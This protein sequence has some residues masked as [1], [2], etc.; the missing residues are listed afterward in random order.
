MA[1]FSVGEKIFN[2]IVEYPL[3]I[4][5]GT[6]D[7]VFY[8]VAA[9]DPFGA[10]GRKFFNAYF[11]NHKKQDAK[12]LEDIIGI[13][14]NEVTQGGVT[15]IRETIIQA[16]G[17]LQR[18]IFPI[19]TGA[20]FGTSE[21]YFV[22]DDMQ[23]R[24]LQN[25]F[26]DGKFAD[27]NNKRKEVIKHL[28]DDSWITIRACNFGQ[29]ADGLYALY[30]FFGGQANVYCPSV[31]QQFN[32]IG[33]GKG[34]RFETKLMAHEHLVKQRILKRDQT[35]ERKA[36]TVNALVDPAKFSIP[37]QLAQK[38]KGDTSSTSAQQYQAFKDN[39]NNR[40]LTD[41]LKTKLSDAQ[42]QLTDKAK[43]LVIKRDS[44]W[45]ILDNI[46]LENIVFNIEYD[47]NEQT[48]DDTIHEQT[49]SVMAEATLR[50]KTLEDGTASPIGDAVYFQLFI[51]EREHKDF[52]GLLFFLGYN[53]S[54]T[55]LTLFTSLI[56]SLDAGGAVSATIKDIFK[57]ATFDL[58]D[59]ATIT[60]QKKGKTW[61]ITDGDHSVFLRLQKAPA[62]N[63]QAIVTVIAVY[64]NLNAVKFDAMQEDLL[65]TPTF[66]KSPNL[67]GTELLAYLD[68]FSLA[69]LQN[70]IDYLRSPYNPE[71]V[72]YIY[73]AISA[74]DRKNQKDFIAWNAT[75][76]D[77]NEQ[78][79]NNPLLASPYN[80]L[81]IREREDYLELVYEFAVND[82][83]K[84][85]KALNAA[86]KV[87]P[88]DLFT[89][90][91][92]PDHNTYEYEDEDE[93]DSPT[94]EIRG[95]DTTHG[96]EVFQQREKV[97]FQVPDIPELDC[98]AY[99]ELLSKIKTLNT[100]NEEKIL[101]AL[102]D[103]ELSEGLKFRDYVMRGSTILNFTMEMAEHFEA[104][105]HSSVRVLN[106]FGHIVESTVFEVLG[107]GLA[108]LEP[109]VLTLEVFDAEQEGVE[110]HE[111]LGRRIATRQ[112]AKQ[113]QIGI[114]G[115]T[116]DFSKKI[117]LDVH[118]SGSADPANYW[119]DRY[120]AEL[121][122]E[123]K[124]PGSPVN[125]F[126]IFVEDVKNGFDEGWEEIEK[127][128]N[129][130]LGKTDEI[131]NLF[132]K[133]GGLSSCQIEAL[134]NSGLVDMNS[135]SAAVMQKFSEVLLD[136]I[137]LHAEAVE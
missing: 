33:I 133:K 117:T 64:N 70:F 32:W 130:A 112:W 57:D 121:A 129:E 25:D 81:S 101:E 100:T 31:Y 125:E 74:L 66:G 69:D 62:P 22:L 115:K 11:P 17:N 134:K 137:P 99:E 91:P 118:L 59:A 40:T 120:V 109:I 51:D 78:L 16:H 72:I 13:L 10:T 98:K 116:I 93:P 12:S 71:N 95:N 37:V 107:F 60:V 36:A 113:L 89:S 20:V 41:E 85:V 14:F 58:T 9:S 102:G 47:L 111:I 35:P 49:V 5:A 61:V 84:Q 104:F 105:A 1:D 77:L 108:V 8:M 119:Y 75:L 73:Q 28:K 21:D 126:N 43:L 123:F 79:R 83:W 50:Q 18:L 48:D 45:I 97:T 87:L 131:F 128:G 23:L 86:S 124:L 55:D 24:L 110:K 68:K 90:E 122:S 63:M 136:K 103:L 127:A 52:T 96:T 34:S 4:K 38:K 15:Q 53:I 6:K 106:L 65:A 56:S 92:L 114:T 132:L 39:L 27:F 42:M 135:V 88:A 3:P 2:E 67:P 76:T 29:N 94:R 44:S 80:E 46:T 7:Y 30:S 82:I 54:G 26:L 19:I